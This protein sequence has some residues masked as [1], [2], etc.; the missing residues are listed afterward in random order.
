MFKTEITVFYIFVIKSGI[1]VL[2]CKDWRTCL[3]LGVE[4]RV[5]A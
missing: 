4:V 1:P 3:D 2:G 5:L